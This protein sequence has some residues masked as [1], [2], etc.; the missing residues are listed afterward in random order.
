MSGEDEAREQQMRELAEELTPAQAHR[1]QFVMKSV[2]QEINPGH[3]R[4]VFNVGARVRMVK[5]TKE[6]R[7]EICRRYQEGETGISL[8]KEFEIGRSHVEKITGRRVA[9][10]RPKPKSV[11]QPV[12]T[13]IERLPET[14]VRQLEKEL[15]RPL[16]FRPNIIHNALVNA[17]PDG[18]KCVEKACPFPA[19]N[20][21]RCRTHLIDLHSEF[22][23]NPSGYEAWS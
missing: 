23:L 19:L 4:T 22:S 7:E 10:R 3:F 11:K 2:R 12:L 18:S 5:V 16:P 8:A 17:K 20:E 13:L 6:M 21:G 15:N 9:E 1:L 14:F